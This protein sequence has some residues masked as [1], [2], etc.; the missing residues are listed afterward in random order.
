MA[1]PKNRPAQKLRSPIREQRQVRLIRSLHQSEEEARNDIHLRPNVPTQTPPPLYP[2]VSYQYA[3]LPTLYV[4]VPNQMWGM[5]LYTY[6]M[7]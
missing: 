3:Y 2:P 4:Y 7:P 1:D 6:G 5:P